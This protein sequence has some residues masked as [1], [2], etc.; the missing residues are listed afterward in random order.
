MWSLAVVV[1]LLG[2]VSAEVVSFSNCPVLGKPA[3]VACAHCTVSVAQSGEVDYHNSRAFPIPISTVFTVGQRLHVHSKK[4]NSFNAV[5]RLALQC[6]ALAL[7]YRCFGLRLSEGGP[8]THRGL[9]GNF[10]LSV[11]SYQDKLLC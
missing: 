10:C 6:I 5:N 8:W 4:N 3:V 11:A 7:S 1:L 2:G 9:R